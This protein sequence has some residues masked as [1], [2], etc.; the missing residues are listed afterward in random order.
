MPGKL[1]DVG[2]HRLHLDC[3]GEGR[4]AVVFD[5]AL[6]GTSL[7]WALVQPEVANFTRACAYDR[8]GSAWSDVGPFP[9]DG[10]TIARE[11]KK[12][13]DASRVPGPY[14]LVGHSYGGFTVRLFAHQYPELVGGMIL[15]DAADPQQWVSPNRVDRIKLDRGARLARRGALVCKLGIARFVVWLGTLGAQ[16][17]A[18][19]ATHLLSDRLP[20][21]ER[22]RLLA[23]ML[24]L[25][26]K[27]R[28]PLSRFW[29]EERFYRALASQIETVPETA[30][31][32]AR[33]GPFGDLP[34]TVVSAPNTDPGWRERQEAVSRLSSRGRHVFAADSSHWIPLDRPDLVVQL[35]REM[36]DSIRGGLWTG[37]ADRDQDH[38]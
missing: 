22:D 31:A 19:A 35:I 18:W 8:A 37:C 25:P 29:T 12:L 23:P 13:L 16:R 26:P 38:C 14:V 17:M 34:L 1:F 36:V 24:R 33:T 15:L 7:S 10:Q 3:R 20:A 27:A 21:R 6:A 2:G 28:R 30:R 32:A 5:S 9:R 4:P 11:L